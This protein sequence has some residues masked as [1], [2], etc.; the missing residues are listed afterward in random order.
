[1]HIRPQ[2][3]PQT[4]MRIFCW[5]KLK[6]W[7]NLCYSTN[8]IQPICNSETPVTFIVFPY[9]GPPARNK[10]YHFTLKYC[11][12]SV[13]HSC[14]K[15]FWSIIEE[16]QTMQVLR[17][18]NSGSHKYAL[19]YKAKVYAILVWLFKTQ[20]ESSKTKASIPEPDRDCIFYTAELQILQDRSYFT[21][22]RHKLRVT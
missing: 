13:F 8:K 5:N 15:R 20:D 21:C 3:N 19:K 12:S 4:P 18:H 16:R 7:S 11:L 2:K 22:P 14:S 17:A 9:T 6:T 1:M 10:L